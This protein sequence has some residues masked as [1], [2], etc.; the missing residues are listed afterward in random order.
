[1]CGKNPSEFVNPMHPVEMVSYGMIRGTS[2][3]DAWVRTIDEGTFVGNMRH[4]AGLKFDL[5]VEKQWEYACRAGTVSSFNNGGND[6]DDLLKLGKFEG[7]GGRTEHHSQV[8]SFVPN[9]WGIY[10]MHGNVRECCLDWTS[11]SQHISRGGNFLNHFNECASTFR[12]H[13][14]SHDGV[15]NYVGFRLVVLP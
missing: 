10:D 9:A 3:G 6:I 1:M 4:R 2:L 8:G 15:R 14:M 13:S 5:P 12:G 7:N 11:A